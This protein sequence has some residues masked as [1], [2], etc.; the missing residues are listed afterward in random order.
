MN[1]Q[2]EIIKPGAVSSGAVSNDAGT[3]TNV[4]SPESVPAVAD[5]PKTATDQGDAG[6][7]QTDSSSDL[8]KQITPDV[9]T[10]VKLELSDEEADMIQVLLSDYVIAYRSDR[11][12]DYKPEPVPREK[13]G[14]YPYV[15]TPPAPEIINPTY[16][17]INKKWYSKNT[18]DSLPDLANTVTDLKAKNEQLYQVLNTVQETQNASVTQSFDVVKMMKQMSEDQ[19]DI[20]KLMGSMQGILFGLGGSKVTQ[21]EASKADTQ[22]TQPSDK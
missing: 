8:K 16:D 13:V 7:A 5:K 14:Q 3:A 21:P 20:K 15:A 1:N 18:S 6:N 4:A 22:S 9:P 19:S 11:S 2:T 12:V 10:S 17:W